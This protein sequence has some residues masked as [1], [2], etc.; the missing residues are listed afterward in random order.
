MVTA[1]SGG[2][3]IK[4]AL[5]PADKPSATMLELRG[6]LRSRWQR[7]KAPFAVLD[8]RRA[9]LLER[10]RLTLPQDGLRLQG[11]GGLRF[12]SAM[13]ARY[14]YLRVEVGHRQLA[15]GI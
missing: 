14:A 3:P 13:R 12:R 4:E 5:H 2:S 15:M 1:R 8:S 9:H 6:S 7:V 10:L 11:S